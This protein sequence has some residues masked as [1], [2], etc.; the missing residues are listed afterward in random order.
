MQAACSPASAPDCKERTTLQRQAGERSARDGQAPHRTCPRLSCG[1]DAHS[2]R[3][4]GGRSL[5]SSPSPAWK[6]S[7]GLGLCERP[8]GWQLAPGRVACLAVRDHTARQCKANTRRDAPG[9]GPVMGA[10]QFLSSIGVWQAPA[11]IRRPA[12]L[13]TSC[14][15]VGLHPCILGHQQVG[16]PAKRATHIGCSSSTME[17]SVAYH[18]SGD[19]V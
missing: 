6:A 10:V 8:A 13:Y 4:G 11:L 3:R 12:A 15:F 7:M 16:G 17:S 5:V 14:C 9:E 2:F 19:G 18:A 1:S